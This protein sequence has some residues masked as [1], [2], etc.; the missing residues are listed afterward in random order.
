MAEKAKYQQQQTP[1]ALPEWPEDKFELVWMKLIEGSVD[2]YCRVD[3]PNAEI[4]KTLPQK[5]WKVSQSSPF[6][7]PGVY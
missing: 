2:S 7:P 1:Y 4:Y 3:P 6:R 5:Y